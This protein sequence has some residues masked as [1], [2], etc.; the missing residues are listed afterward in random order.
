MF[1]SICLSGIAGSVLLLAAACDDQNLAANTSNDN[2]AQ[3]ENNAA[4]PDKAEKRARRPG[5]VL[6]RVPKHGAH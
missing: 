6:G 3:A 4:A 2:A 5:T 1:K